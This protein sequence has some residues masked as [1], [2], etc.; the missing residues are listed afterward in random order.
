MRPIRTSTKATVSISRGSNDKIYI[1]VTD[2][3][4]IVVLASLSLT[5]EEY[6]KVSIGELVSGLECESGVN[7]PRVGKQRVCEDFTVT[8]P[9]SPYSETPKLEAWLVKNIALQE[10]EELR[11]RFGARGA[12]TPCKG[13]SNSCEIRFSV[14][15]WT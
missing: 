1:K 13:D 3:N 2:S 5:L 7:D 12:V 4:A 11:T 10:G 6:A 8:C 14:M 9:L 15:G